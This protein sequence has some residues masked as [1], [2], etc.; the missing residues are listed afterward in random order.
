MPATMPG[1]Q[2]EKLPLREQ[3]STRVGGSGKQHATSSIT[4]ANVKKVNPLLFP[5][6][7]QARQGIGK[8]RKRANRS[9]TGRKGGK[10]DVGGTRSPPHNRSNGVKAAR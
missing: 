1:Y 2:K 7:S 9:E 5:I 6:R 8:K 10:E 3:K 4:E